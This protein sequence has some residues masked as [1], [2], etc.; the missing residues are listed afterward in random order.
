MKRLYIDGLG[1]VDGHFS[2]IGQYILG[3]LK[4]MDELLDDA[5][6]NSKAY[7]Q[8]YVTIP[9]DKV[10]R[11]ESFKFKHIRYKKIPIPFRYTAKLW[12][13]GLMPPLDLFCGP[14]TYIFPR[15]VDMP[16]LFSKNAGL[17]IFDLSYELHRQYSDEGNARFL[18]SRVRRS[19]R[20]TKHVIT[21][22]ENAKKEICNF[23]NLPENDVSVATPAV[24]Q[25]YLYRRS[26][27]EI[28]T[29]KAKYGIVAKNYILA[30]S[31]LEPRKNLQA[32]V[33]AYCSLS[34]K[35]RKDMAL[36]LVGVNGWKADALFD[37]I[38]QKVKDGYE[39]IRPSEY[40]SD[41]DKPAII[42][43]A[44]LLV[45][46]SHYEGFGMPPLEALACGVPVITA[47]NSSLPE[48]V[49]GVGKMVDV[50]ENDKLATVLDTTLKD[51]RK[52]QADAIH[53]GPKRAENFSWKKSAQ[54]FFDIA[55]NA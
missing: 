23:Y 11:F 2:G 17:V 43:G 16:L 26:P 53:M 21:I 36:L 46:P 54:I 45:Y 5:S 48:V 29:I 4:G 3:I 47:D 39:I 55:R 37:E 51:I 7:P 19:V 18:S 32:L 38:R 12:H 33:Y 22:S 30:L 42:S 52:V 10:R 44:S 40:V 24:D 25:S 28:A 14:G 41:K 9:R 13:H 6:S 31:N 35:Q 50:T 20:R 49:Q 34:A 27:E 8:V 15:F 1:L